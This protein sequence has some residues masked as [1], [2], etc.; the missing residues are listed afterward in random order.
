MAV[1]TCDS[2]ELPH[3]SGPV[4][5][6]LNAGPFPR[7]CFARIVIARLTVTPWNGVSLW[8]RPVLNS[9]LRR[10]ASFFAPAHPEERTGEDQQTK[11]Q[12][13]EPQ[14]GDEPSHCAETAT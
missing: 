4:F 6:A 13:C 5:G 12:W 1:E 8:K 11:C 7:R 2:P 10:A 3:V 14:G 9:S